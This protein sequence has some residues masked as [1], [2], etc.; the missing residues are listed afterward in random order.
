MEKLT[1]GLEWFMNP[2]HIPLMVGIKKGWFEEENIDISMVEPE[3]HF[4]AIDEIK[5]GTMDIAITEPLHLV[6]DRANDEP[7]VGFARFLHTNGG[8]MYVK[9][10]GIR[11]PMDLIGKRIQ[12]PG[13]PG[14]GGLAIVKTMVEADGGVCALEDFQPVNN[15]FYHTDALKNDKADAATLIFRNFEMTE[16]KH[17][18]LDVDF[19]ALK[20]WGV[21]DFCQLIFITSPQILQAREAVIQAFL[22]VI[23]KAID[24][25][26]E[27]PEE[28][29]AIYVD[30]TKTDREDE[31]AVA[32]MEA[33]WPCFTY[34]F[35]MTAEYYD[36]LQQWLKSVGKIEKTV[37]SHEYWTNAFVFSRK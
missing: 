36:E 13:A 6:E 25:I 2:D 3:E 31:L 26:Y 1:V 17:E 11:R 20:D 29:K 34:D 19:F 4:D 9:D 23:S 22:K 33:T 10:K 7:V 32:M 35:S 30:Y 21:P 16:A 5:K 8:V 28:A 15:S 37:D 12:Y 14:L 18:G 27:H 24:F